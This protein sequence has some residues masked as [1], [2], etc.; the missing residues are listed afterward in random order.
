M[1]KY[2]QYSAIGNR[3][4]NIAKLNRDGS[5]GKADHIGVETVGD[6]AFF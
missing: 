4:V 3:G 2:V 6:G 5:I 1:V